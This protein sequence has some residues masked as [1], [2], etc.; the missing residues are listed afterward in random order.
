MPPVAFE[1]SVRE[2]LKRSAMI[3]LPVVILI[4][5]I[6]FAGIRFDRQLRV[7]ATEIVE[8]SRIEV[9]REQVVR[10]LSAVDADLRVLANLPLLRRYLD[11]GDPVYRAEIE[12]MFLDLS[13]ET[14]RYDQIRYLDVD[15]QEIIRVNYNDGKPLSVPRARL[16]NKSKRY[17]F[18]DTFGLNQGEIFV[19]PLDLNVEE[20]KVELPH[21]PMIRYGTPVFDGAGRKK[22][23]ILLNYFGNELLEGF[24]SVMQGGKPHGNMLLNR[25][26]YWLIGTDHDD[27]WGFMLGKTDRTFGHDFPEVWRKI[28]VARNGFVLTEQGLFVYT[29]VFPL[30]KEYH[31]STG[32]SLAHAPGGQKIGA[33]EYHWKIVSFVPESA[34]SGDAFYNQ[35]FGRILIFIVYLLLALIAWFLSFVILHRG[36]VQMALRDSA[37]RIQTLLDNVADGIITINE[38]G[39]IELYNPAAEKMFG[40]SASEMIGKNVNTL[41]P[42]PYRSEHDDHLDRYN[43][44]GEMHVIGTVREA[45]GRHKN[46][47]TFPIELGISVMRLGGRRMFAGVLR[48]ITAR[49]ES[50]NQLNLFF[51]LALDLLCIASTDGYFKRVNPAFTKTLGWSSEEILARPFID[52]VHPEDRDST[53]RTIEKH[54][55]VSENILHFENRFQHKDGSWRTL[56]WLSVPYTGGIMFATARDVTA[57]KQTEQALIAARE[58]AELANRAKDSFLATMSHEIRTPLTGMLGMLELLSLSDLDEEQRSTLNAAWE[59]G[60]GLLRI[61]SDIL[62]WSKIE[63]GKL[64]ISLHATSISQLV[65]EVVNTYS[66]VASAKNLV[67]LP[68]V[69]PRLSPAHI[70][71]PLRLSQ[72]LNNFVSNAIKFTAKG[73]VELRVEL[74]DQFNSDERIR[75]SVTD[76]GVGIAKNVQEHLFRR[77]RQEG[78][79]TARL[80]GGTGLGLAICQRL[81][82][83]MDGQIEFESEPGR[84]STFTV[85]LTLPVSEA[86]WEEVKTQNLEVE[87]RRVY[88]LFNDRA[89][90]PLV[91]AV[92][93]H[94]INRDLLACQIEMLGLRTETAKN[95]EVALSMWRDG[96]FALIITDCHMPE[97]DG[98]ALAR[99]IRRIEQKE[100]LSHTPIIAWTANALPSEEKECRGVGM[101]EL[102]VKPTGLRQL[103]DVIAKLLSVPQTDTGRSTTELPHDTTNRRNAPAIDFAELERIMPNL[104]G[105]MDVLHDFLMQIRIDRGRLLELLEEGDPFSVESAAHRM[106][107]SSRMV[108]AKGLAE[109]CSIIELAARDGDIEAARE[110]GAKLD[111]VVKELEGF[112]DDYDNGAKGGEHEQ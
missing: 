23:I 14:R 44:T 43:S 49:K 34:L 28:S 12:E 9:A 66:S 37:T 7:N 100:K 63:A 101:D 10:D 35:P 96:R 85:T 57:S 110:A 83:L 17:Y 105:H 88:P 8:R 18:S 54:V 103:R 52:L 58:Q 4:S 13:R 47:F 79:D 46:G 102:L 33:D 80:Y 15:G 20:G 50:E 21:K 59:S 84:G 76:T 62:D 108:G 70:V 1:V 60:R 65:Q 64:E 95:G 42:E 5:A 51:S 87:Q 48:D 3:Y 39:T 74:V 61:V 41:M 6:L 72:V 26:G 16:Q 82:D 90:A 11:G 112:L 109:L 77:Y 86:P 40:Y 97:M 55:A 2:L 19:S 24:R 56:S 69:D 68:H 30:R 93:D 111:G 38:R 29:T 92:D 73:T 27:E 75:F 81:A 104:T 45:V 53:I 71:N 94:P 25:D 106:K 89:A 31:S 107:G 67:L 36:Q 98:Y 22:G 99:E 91:L 78:P 32:S